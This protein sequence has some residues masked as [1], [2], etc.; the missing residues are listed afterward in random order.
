[1]AT[2][3]DGLGRVA[4]AFASFDDAVIVE[5]DICLRGLFLGVREDFLD[6]LDPVRLFQ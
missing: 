5:E 3:L 6:D 1:M 2:F 4:G